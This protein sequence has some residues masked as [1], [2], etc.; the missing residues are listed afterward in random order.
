[1]SF[2]AHDDCGGDVVGYALGRVDEDENGEN[3][4]S[5]FALS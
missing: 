3:R 2:V 4:E 1:M 5:A